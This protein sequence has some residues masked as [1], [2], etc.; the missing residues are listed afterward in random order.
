MV[1]VVIMAV[2]SEARQGKLAHFFFFALFSRCHFQRS[3]PKPKKSGG[4]Y[5]KKWNLLSC[6]IFI[7]EK[8]SLVFHFFLRGAGWVGFMLAV[9]QTYICL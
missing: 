4:V 7:N 2:V 5:L 3:P 9:V 8:Q 1:A 6:F